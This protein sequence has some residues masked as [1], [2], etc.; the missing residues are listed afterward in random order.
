[1][2]KLDDKRQSKWKL[3]SVWRALYETPL[4]DLLRGR[5]TG[6]LHAQRQLQE[7]GLPPE[8]AELA[9]RVVR[10]TRLRRRERRD[11]VHELIARFSADLASGASPGQII[12][13]F[14]NVRKAAR[15]IRRRK[16]RQRHWFDRAWGVLQW[17][18]LILIVTGLPLL[19]FRYHS[20]EVV[21]AHDY[22]AMLNATASATPEQDRA[23]PLIRDAAID[24]RETMPSDLRIDPSHADDP[25]SQRWLDDVAA[26]EASAAT[27]ARIRDAAS[28]PRL[29]YVVTHDYDPED[30][31]LFGARKEY[32]SY[33]GWD[34]SIA[35][36]LIGLETPYLSSFR[37][38]SRVL[39][40]D[41]HRAAHENDGA[42]ILGNIRAC[43]RLAAMQEEVPTLLNQL[44]AL[45]ARMGVCG[46]IRELMSRSPDA[47]SDA[48]LAELMS[49]VQ[50]LD[51]ATLRLSLEAERWSM[52]D[53]VQRCYTDDG[54]GGG[55]FV[56]PQF[57]YFP[58]EGLRYTKWQGS[59][60]GYLWSAAS[61]GR[62]AAE[63]VINS[64]MDHVEAD[65]D[66]PLW[67]RDEPPM[68]DPLEAMG[69]G[70]RWRLSFVGMSIETLMPATSR[71]AI[72][73]EQAILRRDATLAVIAIEQFR[74]NAR[75]WPSDIEELVPEYLP[76][77][78]I[79]RFDGQPLRYL[80]RS[81]EKPLLYSVGA[82]LLD[83]GGLVGSDKDGFPTNMFAERWVSPALVRS[84]LDGTYVDERDD[85][86]RRRNPIENLLPPDADFIL[87]PPLPEKP[88][89]PPAGIHDR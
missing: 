69:L 52:L 50:R 29:G 8:L 56:I 40:A 3:R 79:D 6:S 16:I 10:R 74:R 75:R 27:L 89:E 80:D 31:P 71:P 43:I 33:D 58:G 49:E 28:M 66:T 38:L 20:G 13:R 12:E 84:I 25:E 62:R 5:V 85:L 11:V 59:I 7:M 41:A 48:Q 9:S 47:F 45:S 86:D 22:V 39:S 14:G 21:I 1:M 51:D 17:A 61:P 4:R 65:A 24:L 57:V 2:M 30:I 76:S 55:H 68:D 18:P 35:N 78:P 54:S 87:W 83:D 42:A 23:W 34:S 60:T 37:Y 63:R 82:N 73:S 67:E 46:L 26:L 70:W 72:T 15:D 32:G 77:L 19:Y 88:I 81:P 44:T 53:T 64:A 36:A